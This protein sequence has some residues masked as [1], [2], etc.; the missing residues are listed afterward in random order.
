MK[1]N[2]DPDDDIHFI[3]IG[4]HIIMCTLLETITEYRVRS[5]NHDT[6]IDEA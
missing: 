4:L 3:E 6:L 1:S 2:I 5:L